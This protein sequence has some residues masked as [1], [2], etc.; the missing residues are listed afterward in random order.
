MR[1]D[2]LKIIFA[3]PVYVPWISAGNALEN[4]SIF[5]ELDLNSL[6]P[7]LLI[8]ISVDRATGEPAA[9]MLTN[10][11]RTKAISVPASLVI[12]HLKIGQVDIAH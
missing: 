9:F 6:P 10:K 4:G 5:T 2:L 7:N 11:N 8:N 3:V 1:V 12:K